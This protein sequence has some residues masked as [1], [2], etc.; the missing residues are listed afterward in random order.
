M[1]NITQLINEPTRVCLTTLTSSKTKD[2]IQYESE[3]DTISLH[4][5]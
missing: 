4:D 1:P 3:C 5:I 2:H